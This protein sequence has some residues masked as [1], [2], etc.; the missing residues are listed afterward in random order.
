M[1]VAELD[2]V[3]HRRRRFLLYSTSVVGAAGMVMAAVPFVESMLPSAKVLVAGG[4]VDVDISKIE[5]GQLITVSWRSKPIWVLRRTKA[6]LTKLPTLSAM[7]KDPDSKEAQQPPNLPHFSDITRSIKPEYLVL[8]AICTHLGCIPTYRPTPKAPDLG[9]TWPGG[10]FCPCHGS[11]Y[12]LAG[13]VMDGSPAPLNLPVPP[14][15][16]K[17]DTVI[18]VGEL[19]NG[20]GANWSPEVW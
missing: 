9:P 2:S 1:S 11:R 7:L 10:F 6:D 20:T 5:E 13:R 3:D 12:D 17:S 16:Y 19:A 18:R 15:Y 4:P 8:V 14:Y